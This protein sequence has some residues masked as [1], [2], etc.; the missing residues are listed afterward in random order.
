MIKSSAGAE[1]TAETSQ[2]SRDAINRAGRQQAAGAAGRPGSPASPCPTVMKI[3]SR[4]PDRVVDDDGTEMSLENWATGQPMRDKIEKL[5]G[6]LHQG[7]LVGGQAD[8]RDQG[9]VGGQGRGPWPEPESRSVLT[10]PAD[11]AGNV[12]CRLAGC[13]ASSRRTRSTSTVRRS[14]TGWHDG[15]H[16]LTR[17]H[18]LSSLVPP[19]EAVPHSGHGRRGG[20]RS[21]GRRAASAGRSCSADPGPR[22]T[23]I[24]RRPRRAARPARRSCRPAGSATRRR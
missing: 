5:V 24:T 4:F 15:H 1:Y 11:P 13:R 19:V 3:L 20:G 14:A 8:R 18:G 7:A 16:T 6:L 9:P 12:G 17:C 21:S 10:F 2:M 22:S 23:R